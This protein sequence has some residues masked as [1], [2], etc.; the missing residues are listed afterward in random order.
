MKVGD[1][2]KHKDVPTGTPGVVV[3]MTQ[4]KVW[5]T[6]VQGKKIDWDIVDPEPHAVVLFSHNDGIINIPVVELEVISASR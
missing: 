5:R 4:K 6:N 2:V 3:D 1:L